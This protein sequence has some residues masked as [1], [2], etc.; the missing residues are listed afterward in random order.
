MHGPSGGSGRLRGVVDSQEKRSAVLFVAFAVELLVLC[1]FALV[2]VGIAR[3]RRA[4]P[5]TPAIAQLDFWW[6][7]W[8]S[9][10]RPRDYESLALTG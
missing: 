10:P 1:V 4:P 7:G 2:L 3:E 8:G 5:R 6:G 9:N